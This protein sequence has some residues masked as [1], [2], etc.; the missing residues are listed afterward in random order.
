[1]KIIGIDYSLTSPAITLYNGNDNWNYNSGSCTHFCLASN[2][3]QRSKW[4]EIRSIRTD[5]YPA[6][7]TDLQRYHGLANWVIN[8]CITAISPER[9]KAY[10]ED[11][12]YAATGRVFH[13]AE[14]MAILKDTLTKWGIKYE[15]IAPTVIKKY[16]TTK[17][18]ANKEKMYDAFTDET[19]R[20]LLD[21]FNIKLNNPITDIVDSYYIAKYGHA[22]G[23]NT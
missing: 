23:N 14:N 20:K 1:M 3:R 15:M 12:A 11:Y 10:I 8:C 9:P 16:A 2:E 4:A 5:I 7:E 6:W 17:G 21:E 18:N 13:I 19:N 22:Y